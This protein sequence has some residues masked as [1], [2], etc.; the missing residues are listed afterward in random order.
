M[1]FDSASKETNI[2][3]SELTPSQARL[4]PAELTEEEAIYF[5]GNWNLNA[6]FT[7]LDIPGFHLNP[8]NVS[9]RLNISL[10]E[11]QSCIESL[12]RLNLIIEDEK[13]F[14]SPRPLSFTDSIVNSADLLTVFNR[15]NQVASGKMTSKDHFAHQFEILSKSVIRKFLPEIYSLVSKIAQESKGA[16]DCDVYAF[17]VSFTKTSMTSKEK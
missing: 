8:E 9:K 6:T 7:L 5:L 10:F 12:A 15:L 4:S 14:F 11:A 16:H 17:S 3:N 1:P 2:L 13:G